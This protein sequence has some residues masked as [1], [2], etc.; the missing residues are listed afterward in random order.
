MNGLI[1][2]TRVASLR[3]GW[4]GRAGSFALHSILVTAALVATRPAPL[5]PPDARTTTTL[6]WHVPDPVRPAP[7]LPRLPGVPVI[8]GPQ[9]PVLV[10]PPVVPSTVPPP[11]PVTGTFEPAPGPVETTPAA[12]PAP[13]PTGVMEMRYVEELPLLLRH[14]ALRYPELLRQAGIEGDVLVEAVLDTTGAVERAS[15]RVLRSSH[16]LFQAD[17]LALVAGSAY[18]P[19]RANGRAVRVRIAVPVHFA[20]R[21]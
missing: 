10:V 14:P 17:A 19:A 18:R 9:A 8:V 12:P 16:A 3:G 11:G 21:R 5:A 7:A 15:L 13:G 1:E 2:S 4:A 6:I 20:L